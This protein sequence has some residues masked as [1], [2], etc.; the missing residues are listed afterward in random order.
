MFPPKK[1]QNSGR[2]SE[3]G[4]K[5]WPFD[6]SFPSSSPAF[7]NPM[8][9]PSLARGPSAERAWWSQR[10]VASAAPSWGKGGGGGGV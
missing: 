4:E 5:N 10:L 3:P 8:P 6:L 7:L 1:L 9:T 2:V